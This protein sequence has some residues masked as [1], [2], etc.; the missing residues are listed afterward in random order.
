MN[1]NNFDFFTRQSVDRESPIPLH[2]QIRTIILSG[3]KSG[4]L[5]PGELIPTELDL[6]SLFNISRTTIRQALTDLVKDSHLYRIKSKGTFIAK[7]KIDFHYMT[8]IESFDKQVKNMGMIP[9]TQ[10]LE[11]QTVPAEPVIASGL[12][13]REGEKIIKLVRLRYA[14][15]DPVV[16]VYSYHPHDICA[17]MADIDFENVSL[18]DTFAK[19]PETKI[20]KVKRI[21]EAAAS[22]STDAS[23]LKVKK[24]FPIQAFE[25]FSYNRNGRIVEYCL[26]RYRGDKNRFSIEIRMD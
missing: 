12:G 23:L 9:R 2:F 24:G 18:L 7:P 6:S 11:F 8:G 13:I 26:S 10:V 19:R 21:V 17:F 15:D 5:K 4:N 25:N 3:I 16:V 20:V 22:N 1:V 14:D